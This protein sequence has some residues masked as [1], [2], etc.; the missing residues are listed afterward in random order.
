MIMFFYW[1]NEE[2]CAPQHMY[3]DM[4]RSRGMAILRGATCST[5]HYHTLKLGYTTWRWRGIHPYTLLSSL[6]IS[7]QRIIHVS[8][9]FPFQD[10]LVRGLWQ[11]VAF[12]CR[13]LSTEGQYHAANIRLM[14]AR[15]PCSHV[16]ECHGLCPDCITNV[17]LTV[18]LLQAQIL[19]RINKQFTFSGSRCVITG[20]PS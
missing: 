4:G 19:Q 11:S 20:T 17:K 1:P 9:L 12:G 6:T 2:R 8:G 15:S 3:C 10:S 5:R 14:H 16:Y 13:Q 18:F 7:Y